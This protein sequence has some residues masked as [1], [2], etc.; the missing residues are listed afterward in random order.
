MIQNPRHFVQ[1]EFIFTSYL[2][3]QSVLASLIAILG[4]RYSKKKV[5]HVGVSGIVVGASE[6]LNSFYCS[7]IQSIELYEAVF[8]G[9]NFWLHITKNKRLQSLN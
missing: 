7:F 6:K 4:H 9:V 1:T 3:L 5:R 8:C 2:Y